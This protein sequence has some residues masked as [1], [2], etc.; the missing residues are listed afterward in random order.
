[1]SD[2]MRNFE[3]DSVIFDKNKAEMMQQIL[4]K[5]LE[6]KFDEYRSTKGANLT[7]GLVV[8]ISR[9]KGCHATPIAEKLLEKLNG[10]KHPVIKSPKWRLLSKEILEESSKKLQINPG[11]LE[12][13]LES[14]EKNVVEEIIRSLSGENYPSDLKI[15]NTIRE[16]VRSAVSHGNVL[17]LGR[18]GVAI[19]KD[20]PK[21]L[22]IRLTAPIE[23]RARQLSISYNWSEVRALKYIQKIDNNRKSLSD[24]YFGKPKG[25]EVF[26]LIFNLSKIKPKEVVKTIYALINA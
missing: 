24:F 6:A 4:S 21:S 10:P 13:L 2:Q 14:H 8:T 20:I 18:G 7:P 11:N 9:A 23:W 19:T 17:I 3:K 16:V 25:D 5:F 1:M 15:K 12:R 22:H 26:D